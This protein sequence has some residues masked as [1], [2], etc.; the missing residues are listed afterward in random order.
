MRDRSRSVEIELILQLL[1]G[2]DT[3]GVIGSDARAG[4]K[5]LLSNTYWVT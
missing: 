2:E 3:G 4:L 1:K 5:R